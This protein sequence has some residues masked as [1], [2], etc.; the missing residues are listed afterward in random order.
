MIRPCLVAVAGDDGVVV[1]VDDGV[2]GG[3]ADVLIG[4]SAFFCVYRFQLHAN[5]YLH[6]LTL[7][8]CCI[9]L[10]IPNRLQ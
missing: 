10:L 8:R 6:S 1:G 7:P 9:V 2:G 3:V 4:V 5:F